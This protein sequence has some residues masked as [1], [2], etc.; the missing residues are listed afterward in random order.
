[1]TAALGGQVVLDQNLLDDVLDEW[2]RRQ[3]VRRLATIPSVEEGSLAD[4]GSLRA[5]SEMR[6]ARSFVSAKSTH[7]LLRHQTSAAASS[8][9]SITALPELSLQHLSARLVGGA[10]TPSGGTA[11][12]GSDLCTTITTTTTTASMTTTGGGGGGAG[13]TAAAG[14]GGGG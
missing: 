1:M 6:L 4:E 7:R 13:L 10:A 5:P 2:R 3:E 14:G 11:G 12:G 9:P 8:N